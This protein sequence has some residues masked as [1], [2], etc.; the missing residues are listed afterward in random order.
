MAVGR[1]L[2]RTPERSAAR[3]RSELAF[4]RTWAGLRGL[5]RT[6]ALSPGERERWRR[7]RETYAVW[8]LRVRHPEVLERMARVGARLAAALGGAFVPQPLDQ[9]HVTVFVAGFPSPA[10]A[11][12]DDVAESALRAQAALAHRLG[13]GPLR[14]EVGGANGF[15]TCPFLEVLD[16]AGD[17]ARLR[18]ALA[19][20]APEIR[21]SDY[22]P[23]VTVGFLPGGVGTEPLRACLSPLRRLPPL[24][25]R[26]AEVELVTYDAAT[27]GSPLITASKV[28][29]TGRSPGPARRR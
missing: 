10:P 20:G 17:L 16:P 19:A 22:H 6:L 25:L 5:E 2:S 11:L 24:R 8:A 28:A 18:R 4:A 26:P 14:L 21:F 27:P 9:A 1:A 12:D 3:S 13:L 23:H 15:L 29:F 7:G